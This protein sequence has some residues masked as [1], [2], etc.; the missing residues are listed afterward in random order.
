ME[1]KNFS[2]GLE[3]LIQKRISLCSEE[4]LFIIDQKQWG[5][6]II[7]MLKKL[8]D[9]A[10]QEKVSTYYADARLKSEQA[11]LGY[12]VNRY[13]SYIKEHGKEDRNFYELYLTVR[14]IFSVCV[15]CP[16]VI[17]RQDIYEFWHWCVQN[18]II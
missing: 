9:K 4:E 12:D 3:T 1:V 7:Q 16:Y 18:Q 14:I 10:E 17:P 15:L 2:D 8:C 5:Y 6:V 13:I 11:K